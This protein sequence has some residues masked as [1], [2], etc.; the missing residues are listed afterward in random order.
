[1]IFYLLPVRIIQ[2][3]PL[4]VTSLLVPL[5][6]VCLR[7][8]RDDDHNRQSAHDASKHIFQAMFSPVIMLLLGGF[9]IAGALSKYHIAKI[10]ATFVLSKAGTKPSTVLLANMF[11]ATFASM[12]I[13]NV[14]APVLC[15]SIIQ[16]CKEKFF[17]FFFDFFT[18][19]DIFF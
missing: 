8:L 18:L 5:L 6:V 7:V 13:S 12:W 17:F 19:V 3:I 15:L 10:L 4:F 2:V 9:A 16:V 1:M 11:V 14:A